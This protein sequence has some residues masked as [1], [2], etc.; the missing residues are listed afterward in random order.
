MWGAGCAAG[1][2]LLPAWRGDGAHR[3][4][5]ARA[6]RQGLKGK[7]GASLHVARRLP[8]FWILWYYRV[9]LGS[10]D[11]VRGIR[12]MCVSMA[13]LISAMSVLQTRFRDMPSQNEQ[14]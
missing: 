4:D 12:S 9:L 10:V 13:G 6:A 1:H 5:G 11:K 14:D 2:L 7:A 8:K 3:A